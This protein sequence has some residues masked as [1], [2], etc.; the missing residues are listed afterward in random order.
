VVSHAAHG[1]EQLCHLN[2]EEVEQGGSATGEG[3]GEGASGEGGAGGEGKVLRITFSDAE[4]HCKGT[5]DAQGVI[6]GTV[7][8]LIRPEEVGAF[9]K[10]CPPRQPPHYTPSIRELNHSM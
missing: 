5:I 9:S 6:T 8:Q 1:D 7:G 10:S 2:I 4:T 3:E